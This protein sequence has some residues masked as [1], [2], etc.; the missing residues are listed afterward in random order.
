M[1][2]KQVCQR[3]NTKLTEVKPNCFVTDGGKIFFDYGIICL[4]LQSYNTL[5]SELESSVKTIAV[6]DAL[7]APRQI[8]DGV[9][10]GRNVLAILETLGYIK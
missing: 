10:E 9:R 6:G 1:R 2:N 7:C 4:G 5:S 3:P 8:I